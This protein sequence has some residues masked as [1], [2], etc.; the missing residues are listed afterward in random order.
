MLDKDGHDTDQSDSADF[1][2]YINTGQKLLEKE[3]YALFFN[4]K[5]HNRLFTI[6]NFKNN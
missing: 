5:C 2:L 6:I 3:D 4:V 1:C